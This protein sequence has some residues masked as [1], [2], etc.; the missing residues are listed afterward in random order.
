LYRDSASDPHRETYGHDDAMNM[1]Q[2]EGK[3]V[4]ESGDESSG[5]EDETH[6]EEGDEEDPEALVVSITSMC[7]DRTF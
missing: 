1:G 2:E 3:V 5:A 6:D 7:T 4:E